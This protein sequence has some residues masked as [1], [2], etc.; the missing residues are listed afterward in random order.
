VLSPRDKRGICGP[1][2]VPQLRRMYKSG[3]ISNTTLFWAEGEEDW[4][5]LMYQRTLKPKVLQLPVLPPK[6]GTFNAERAVY[7]P[8]VAAPPV[9]QLEEAEDLAGFDIT[10]SCFKC[11][12]MAVA[13]IRSAIASKPPPDL[14]KG[15]TEIGTTEFTAEILPGLLWVGQAAAAKQRA[16]LRIGITLL[17]N[18]TTNMKGPQSQPPAFRCREAPMRD[19]PKQ[20]F[21]ED[22]RNEYLALFERVYDQIEVH[23]ITPELAAKSDPAPKEYRGPTDKLGMPIKTA[24]DLKVLRRP[25]DD[26]TPIF[27]PRILLWSRLGTDRPCAL[28]AAYIIKHYGVT[29]EHAVH[30][31]RA[32]RTNAAI[33]PPYME[34]LHAWSARYTLGLLICLD[35]QAKVDATGKTLGDTAFDAEQRHREAAARRLAR[36]QRVTEEGSSDSEDSDI[37]FQNENAGE[38]ERDGGL[39]A[40]SSLLDGS[41]Q[42]SEVERRR[43]EFERSLE[44]TF[45]TFVQLM[46]GHLYQMLKDR[47]HEL[48]VL[49][50]VE[51]YLHKVFTNAVGIRQRTPYFRWNR[52]MDL[53]L[54][55]RYLSDLTMA[56]LFQLLAGNNLIRQIRQLKLQSNLIASQA[57]KALLIAYFPDGHTSDD[58]YHF[59]DSQSVADVDNNFDLMLLDLSNNK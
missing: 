29:V 8:I 58:N 3:E 20:S 46:K 1:F 7:D 12:S 6:V 28:A 30:I 22:E 13:H 34:L 39:N 9:E 55:G 44:G 32:N 24:A 16:L 53:E 49:S 15:R 41:V 33:S 11:G 45:D 2:S 52:L 26:E 14:F 38:G 47:P 50:K 27:A 4:Q 36:L 18:C 51:T 25:K 48:T 5:Q 43:T 57:V 21:T 37:G 56:V 54:S 10:K 31:V 19:G 42:G 35:C 40:D 59:D 17:F 23:R